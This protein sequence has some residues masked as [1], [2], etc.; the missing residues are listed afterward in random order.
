MG[1]FLLLINFEVWMK[2]LSIFDLRFGFYVSNHLDS[3]MPR[4]KLANPGQDVRKRMFAY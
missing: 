4:S 1:S 3:L 2:E